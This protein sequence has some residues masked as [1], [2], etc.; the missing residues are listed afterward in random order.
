MLN[1]ECIVYLS[2]YIN[3]VVFLTTTPRIIYN[4]I[5]NYQD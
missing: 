5:S 2:T 4:L 1:A 3:S